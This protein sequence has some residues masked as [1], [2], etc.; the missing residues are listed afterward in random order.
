MLT[1]VGRELDWQRKREGVWVDVNLRSKS[2]R[3]SGPR[4]ES[5]SPPKHLRGR[6]KNLQYKSFAALLNEHSFSM[7]S[8]SRWAKFP[9]RKGSLDR[10]VANRKGGGVGRGHDGRA[11]RRASGQCRTARLAARHRAARVERGRTSARADARKQTS[12]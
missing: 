5:K 2:R 9:I 12:A 1:P 10:Y 3:G 8:A 4:A 7:I 11:D 6:S